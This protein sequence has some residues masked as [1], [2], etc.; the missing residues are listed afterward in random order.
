MK[1][2]KDFGAL[3]A[4]ILAVIGAAVTYGALSANAAA[5]TARIDKLEPQVQT[6]TTDT[7]VLKQLAQDMQQ[8][9]NRIEGALGTKK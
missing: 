2:L 3:V 6:N 8:S 9:L 1:F 7:A 5:A 4:I